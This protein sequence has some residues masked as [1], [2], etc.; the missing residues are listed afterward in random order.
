MGKTVAKNR[1]NYGVKTTVEV[2]K[3]SRKIVG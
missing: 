1:K 2:K 3:K